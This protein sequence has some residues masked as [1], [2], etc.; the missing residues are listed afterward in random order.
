MTQDNAT[1]IRAIGF[2]LFGTLAAFSID[3]QLDYLVQNL[4]VSSDDLG[5][6]LLSKLK[7]APE[8]GPT[9]NIWPHIAD[10]LGILIPDQLVEGWQNDFFE[11]LV[12]PELV[13]LIKRLQ[14][15]GYKVGLL[16]NIEL[17]TVLPKE[18]EA[19]FSLFDVSL[20]SDE[21]KYAKPQAEAYQELVKRLGAKA[22]EVVFIDDLPGNIR[23]AETA[24]LGGIQYNNSQQVMNQLEKLGVQV[25]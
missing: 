11:I 9:G 17:G 18:F 3:D 10:E 4:G 23:G 25:G 20:R 14:R 24:G 5:A 12:R 21:I 7:Y 2:D 16:S 8:G 1:K 6:A 19:V 22:E 15:N 13:A